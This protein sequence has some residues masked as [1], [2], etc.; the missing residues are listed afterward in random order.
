MKSALSV[1]HRP[2]CNLSAGWGEAGGRRDGKSLR[3]FNLFSSL[4]FVPLIPYGNTSS[5]S[6]LHGAPH[7]C[8][9]FLATARHRSA[10][11]AAIN[12]NLKFN[13][14]NTWKNIIMR[15]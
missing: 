5:S 7:R 1:R 13:L 9:T 15:V 10:A 8:D 11:A 4:A 3:F 2:K 14:Q 6:H 12:F